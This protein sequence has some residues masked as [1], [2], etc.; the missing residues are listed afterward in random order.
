MA[1]H[2]GLSPA[3]TLEN[4]AI[5]LYWRTRSSLFSPELLQRFAAIADRRG[6]PTF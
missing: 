1:P 4:G 6:H 2:L 3:A 5:R